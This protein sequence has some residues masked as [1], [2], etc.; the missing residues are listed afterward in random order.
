MPV[1]KLSQRFG[2]LLSQLNAIEATKRHVISQFSTNYDTV[3]VDAK[4]AWEVKCRNLLAAA[5]GKE[6]EHYSQFIETGKPQ[7]FRNEWEEL[8][9]LKAVMLAAQEDYDGGYLDSV[10]SLAQ[11][12]VFSEELDQARELI[13]TG[14]STPAAVVAGVV[15]ETKLRNMVV[16]AGLTPGKLSKMNEDLTKAGVYNLT[17]QKRITA[18]ADIRNNA[19]HG[20]SSK[21][22]KDDVEDLIQYTERFL[23]DHP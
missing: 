18:L 15:L 10:Q 8:Q 16:L 9:Q 20:H 23:A 12:E 6:S 5:C 3:D 1:Q 13:R 17:V 11:A 4:L 22:T 21:F 19:A 2:E 7:S 14:Y